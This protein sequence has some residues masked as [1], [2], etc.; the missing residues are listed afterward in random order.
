MVF[1]S[2]T[3]L[4]LFFPVVFIGY[5]VIPKKYRNA[6]L[7]AA[8]LIFYSWGGSGF[9]FILL[10][11][12]L[13][14][15]SMALVIEKNRERHIKKWILALPLAGN[16]AILI[17][18]KYLHFLADIISSLTSCSCT[19]PEILLPIGISF[20]T[21]Q[22]I[23]YIVD[24]YRGEKALKNPVDLG[25]YITFFPQ[26]I[27][28]PIVRFKEIRTYI[29]DR[30]PDKPEIFNGFE[31]F[32]LGLC[33]KV[34]FANS[35]GSIADEMINP[36]NY[37][38]DSVL[39]LWTRAAAFTL[40]IYYDFSGYSDMAIGLGHMFGFSFPENFIYPY[41]ASDFHDFWKRWHITLSS[42]FRDYV[43][44]PLGGSRTTKL[45]H[46]LNLLTVWGLSGLWHGASWTFIAWGLIYFVL[47]SLEKYV[48]KPNRF[49]NG[50]IKT[51]YRFFMIICVGCN[52]VIFKIPTLTQAGNYLAAMS[53]MKG[54]P[55]YN[56]Y[57]LFILRNNRV[58]IPAA[59]LFVMPVMP[60]LRC[61]RHSIFRA[62][63]YFGLLLSVIMS[64][65]SIL[66]DAYNPF[67]YFQF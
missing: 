34:I 63:Y 21:F 33:K 18:F 38:S 8:S 17:Y 29:H 55:L 54:L 15:Y 42:W 28:G 53:G 36:V 59:F 14:N 31:R 37:S 7:F 47:L 22:E 60:Y 61:S 49:S 11:S 48:I 2:S 16:I 40:Q 52:W 13:W 62:A 19:L 27:A 46:I 57:S 26:L 50:L 44:I 65:A 20:Y 30:E 6:F 12:L 9:L 3:F 51:L 43:Y 64:V 39:L 5:Y 35:L 45:R 24:V 10:S 4:F 67:L 58:L 32:L 23:S 41:C 1:S 66:Q 25:M 56:R